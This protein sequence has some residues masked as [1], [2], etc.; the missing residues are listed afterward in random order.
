MINKI[1]I[2]ITT[3][4]RLKDLIYT[5][6]HM[7]SIGFVE[8]QFIIIDDGSTDDTYITIRELF[9]NINIK[10]NAV[11]RGYMVNRSEMMMLSTNDYILSLDDDSNILRK[12][13]IEEAISILESNKYYGIFHFRVFNQTLPPPGKKELAPT[14]RFLRG[15]IG[16]GH[17]IKREVIKHVGSYREDLVFYCEE[18]DYAL[19]AYRL[20]YYTVSQD[21]LIVHHRIDLLE[22]QKQKASD[23][24]KGIYGREWRNIHLY[25]NNL[26]IT[27]LYYPIGI[28]LIFI[29]YRLLLAFY[30]MVIME[31]QFKAYFVMIKRFI[32]FTSYTIRNAHKLSYKAFFKWFSYPDMSDANTIS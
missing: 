11:S 32:A 7:I 4:N 5:I 17:I 6:N 3:K 29:V 28:D 27:A 19:R 25:S 23:N 10:F 13:D 12:E 20:G 8:S 14:F 18:L 22:R 15:Y 1:D 21:N 26:L 30:K 16:C 24:S 31:R 2:I 9:P